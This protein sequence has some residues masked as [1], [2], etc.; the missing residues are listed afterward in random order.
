[1]ETKSDMCFFFH[2]ASISMALF[3]H[4][5]P[6]IKYKQT[7]NYLLSP[8]IVSSHITLRPRSRRFN[9]MRFYFRHAIHFCWCH[10]VQLSEFN[11]FNSIEQPIKVLLSILA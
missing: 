7:K 1:M 10:S 4:S 11:L 8:L 5:S 9:Q 6:R 2:F 3:S